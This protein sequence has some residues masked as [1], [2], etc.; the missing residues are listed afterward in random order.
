[1]KLCCNFSE[2]YFQTIVVHRF[3]PIHPD[4]QSCNHLDLYCPKEQF[5]L[6]N[7]PIKIDFLLQR[8]KKY[9]PT[10]GRISL[11]LLLVVLKLLIGIVF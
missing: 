1:M 3:S 6:N 9:R 8:E 10:A 11:L 5:L 2:D 4:Y 7:H